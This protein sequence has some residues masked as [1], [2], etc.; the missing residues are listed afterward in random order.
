L[1]LRYVFLY[2]TLKTKTAIDDEGFDLII[3]GI[4]ASNNVL[5]DVNVRRCNISSNAI[6]DARRAHPRLHIDSDF[7]SSDGTSRRNSQRARVL[8]PSS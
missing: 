7:C 3:A 8:F 5:E 4:A 2:V 1:F 6:D